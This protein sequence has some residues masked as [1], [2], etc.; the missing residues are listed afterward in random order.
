MGYF[1]ELSVFVVGGV[2]IR[3]ELPTPPPLVLTLILLRYNHGRLRLRLVTNTLCPPYLNLHMI[4]HLLKYFGYII[5]YW[6]IL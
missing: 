1:W 6:F 3:S 4:I 5:L 2:T